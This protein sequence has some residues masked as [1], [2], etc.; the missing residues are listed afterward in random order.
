MIYGQALRKHLRHLHFSE[1]VPFLKRSTT[2]FDKKLKRKEDILMPQRDGKGPPWG[3]GRGTG[4]K[5]R[6]FESAKENQLSGNG[7]RSQNL[8]SI[9]RSAVTLA[10]TI[11]NYFS[12]KKK[13]NKSS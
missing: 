2:F 12:F 3:S 1:G 10:V 13:G 5:R 9:I 7:D 4:Y 11:V 8:L 6:Q